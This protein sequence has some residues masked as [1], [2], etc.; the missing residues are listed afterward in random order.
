MYKYIYKSMYMCMYWICMYIF[1]IL[2]FY[3]HKYVC[4]CVYIWVSISM[5]IF[6]YIR[7]TNLRQESICITF[8]FENEISNS[9]WAFYIWS[10]SIKFCMLQDNNFRMKGNFKDLG[11]FQARWLI[12]TCMFSGPCCFNWMRSHF[13]LWA[14]LIL[15]MDCYTPC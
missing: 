7:K 11:N 8:W 13:L 2:W 9:F 3:V 1:A 4:M 15:S 5:F 12:V 14:I 6:C 10:M